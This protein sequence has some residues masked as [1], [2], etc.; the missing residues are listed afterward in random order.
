MAR[1]EADHR[2]NGLTPWRF[3]CKMVGLKTGRYSL[4]VAVAPFSKKSAPRN[5]ACPRN[6][7]ELNFCG[8]SATE[9]KRSLAFI[10]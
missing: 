5:V 4:V 2:L 3:L 10:Q 6:A 9:S 8:L 1:T 7:A